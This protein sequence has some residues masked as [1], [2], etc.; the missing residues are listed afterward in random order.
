VNWAGDMST[1]NPEAR[2]HPREQLLQSNQKLSLSLQAQLSSSSEQPHSATASPV[3]PPCQWPSPLSITPG[4]SPQQRAPIATFF[5][6]S[7]FESFGLS[8]SKAIADRLFS[9]LQLAPVTCQLLEMNL[10]H[11]IKTLLLSLP[12][13]P[14]KQTHIHTYISH[15]GDASDRPSKG[16][17]P[18]SMVSVTGESL[19]G[20]LP[21]PRTGVAQLCWPQSMEDARRAV[22]RQDC[23]RRFGEEP[24][25]SQGHMALHPPVLP[26][27][28]SSWWLS[29]SLSLCPL[30]LCAF[31]CAQK[32][33]F[34]VPG[35]LVGMVAA[36]PILSD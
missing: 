30:S 17:C 10:K 12:Q 29:G 13:H 11:K 20:Y 34:R 22:S 18:C 3:S 28:F 1:D 36:H 23:A 32:A 25:T 5:F 26:P 27:C 33:Q 6:P 8:A 16:H 4:G 14:R 21:S 24:G 31:M 7:H 9:I 15:M 19:L 35:Q 2:A